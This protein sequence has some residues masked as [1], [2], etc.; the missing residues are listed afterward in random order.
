MNLKEFAKVAMLRK[1]LLKMVEGPRNRVLGSTKYQQLGRVMN[2]IIF[3]GNPGSAE[4]ATW[5]NS[6]KAVRKEAVRT[7][8]K[9][10]LKGR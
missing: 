8:H 6:S 9:E 1:G 10:L 5:K 7:S 4:R 3:R 2:K